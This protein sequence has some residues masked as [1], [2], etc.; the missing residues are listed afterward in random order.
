MSANARDFDRYMLRGSDVTVVE[1]LGRGYEPFGDEIQRLFDWMG[2]RQRTTRKRS[3][4]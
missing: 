2:R 1:Y 3:T 4:A